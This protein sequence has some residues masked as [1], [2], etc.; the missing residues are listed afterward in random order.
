MP[1]VVQDTDKVIADSERDSLDAR[2]ALLHQQRQVYAPYL[3]IYLLTYL[4]T[5]LL[6]YLLTY[7]STYLLTHLLSIRSSDS[8]DGNSRQNK[9]LQ[10]DQN[11]VLPEQKRPKAA[12]ISVS[13]ALRQTPAYTAIL[14]WIAQ[15]ASLSFSFLWYSL[16]LPTQG[17][18][19]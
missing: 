18:P 10:I 9:Q 16:H 8:A 7:L 5:Y 14:Q 15:F 4:L 6:I 13:L 2:V 17:W 3:L 1:N 19:G 11:E 12:L